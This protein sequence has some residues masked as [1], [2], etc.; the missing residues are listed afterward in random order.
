M[1]LRP[2][3]KSLIILDALKPEARN[4]SLTFQCCCSDSSILIRSLS[5]SIQTLWLYHTVIRNMVVKY[6]LL[7]WAS[8]SPL[9][10]TE[11]HTL[12]LPRWQRNPASSPIQL[13]NRQTSWSN[14]LIESDSGLF[15]IN[16]ESSVEHGGTEKRKGVP[17]L[18]PELRWSLESK[19]GRRVINGYKAMIRERGG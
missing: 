8:H 17:V 18:N 4:T 11:D 1:A 12:S 9:A 2:A 7:S 15:W 10:Q 13:L 6:P 5:G 19:R 14:C 3:E 16:W